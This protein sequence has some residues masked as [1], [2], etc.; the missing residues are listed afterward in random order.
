MES[1]RELGAYNSKR[2]GGEISFRTISKAF[3]KRRSLRSWGWGSKAYGI[4]KY[5]KA[6]TSRSN[7]CTTASLLIYRMAR[8]LYFCKSIKLRSTLNYPYIPLNNYSL[9]S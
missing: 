4:L 5:Y 7:Y 8:V 3:S 1:S 2:L 6:S 9:D